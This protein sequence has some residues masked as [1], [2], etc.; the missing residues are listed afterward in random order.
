MPDEIVLEVVE[1]HGER[2]FNPL[3]SRLE[4]WPPI[5]RQHPGDAVREPDAGLVSD[6]YG[7]GPFL[8]D[9]D[10]QVSGKPWSDLFDDSLCEVSDPSEVRIIG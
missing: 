5:V 8:I 10:M 4:M 7:R 1:E 3:H 6:L 2:D 9:T